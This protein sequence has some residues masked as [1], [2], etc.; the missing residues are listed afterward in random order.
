MVF[1]IPLIVIISSIFII[2]HFYFSKE[3]EIIKEQK[4]IEQKDIKQDKQK[5][6]ENILNQK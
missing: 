6:L 4:Q 3:N 5:Y 1:L 2:D